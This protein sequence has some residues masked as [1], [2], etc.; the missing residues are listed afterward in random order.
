MT[1]IR[2]LLKEES[3]W[4]DRSVGRHKH[5]FSRTVNVE[6]QRPTGSREY[7]LVRMCETCKSFR[8]AVFEE[9]ADEQFETVQ[10][11]NN[12]KFIIGFKDIVCIDGGDEGGNK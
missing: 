10:F 1:K 4:T 3:K 11:W 9:R 5:D 6:I 7:Y 8:D 12:H 2:R